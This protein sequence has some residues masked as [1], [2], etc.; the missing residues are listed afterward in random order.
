MNKESEITVDTESED[1]KYLLDFLDENLVGSVDEEKLRA[2]DSR[3]W[4][5]GWLGTPCPALGWVPPINVI[6]N[7][8]GV[9]G[10]TAVKR[11][12][13]CAFAGTYL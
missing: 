9:T 8:E 11:V 10:L 12:L 13:D 1:F 6:H 3:K 7:K 5:I 2:F 4:L